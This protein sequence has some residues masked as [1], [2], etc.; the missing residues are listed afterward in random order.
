MTEFHAQALLEIRKAHVNADEA[1]FRD[2][3]ASSVTNHAR[4]FRY[5]RAASLYGL[6][7][8]TSACVGLAAHHVRGLTGHPSK[9]RRPACPPIVH[10]E[11]TS[12]KRRLPADLRPRYR[13]LN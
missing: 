8:A 3:L 12:A 2:D 13:T 5:A 1:E 11:I 4:Y 9:A 7:I 6:S 10:L